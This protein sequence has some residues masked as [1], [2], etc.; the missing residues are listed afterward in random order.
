[1]LFCSRS[2]SGT[3]YNV[4]NGLFLVDWIISVSHR[5]WLWVAGPA[6]KSPVTGLSNT[7]TASSVQGKRLVRQ[8][9]GTKLN[10][11]ACAVCSLQ[12]NEQTPTTQRHVHTHRKLHVAEILT[13]LSP[14]LC[15]LKVYHKLTY[16]GVIKN[17]MNPARWRLEKHYNSLA[18]SHG[19]SL[20]QQ[21]L[22]KTS[23]TPEPDG[24][25]F[26]CEASSSSHSGLQFLQE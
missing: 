22:I 9:R 13:T 23:S 16:S 7:K 10:Q 14:T 18:L 12:S 6:I 1:M 5:E 2:P 19:W 17:R 20:V 21:L 8:P 24:Y 3:A 25:P 4:P 15:Q 26:V 11:W